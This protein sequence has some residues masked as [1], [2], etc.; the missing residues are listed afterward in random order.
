MNRRRRIRLGIHFPRID[1][2]IVVALFA[3]MISALIRWPAKFL[4]DIAIPAAFL[5]AF[6]VWRER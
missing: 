5:I 4:A 1:A 6:M 3:V 2:L